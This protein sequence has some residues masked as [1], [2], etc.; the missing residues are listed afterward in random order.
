MQEGRIVE[1]HS[2]VSKDR[3]HSDVTG[4]VTALLLCL[5]VYHE[6]T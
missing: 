4:A 3:K 6:V 2:R 1:T 5:E